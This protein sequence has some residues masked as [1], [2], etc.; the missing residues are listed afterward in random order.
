MEVWFFK[1]VSLTSKLIKF[2]TWSKYSH[3]SLKFSDDML[4]EAWHKTN[5]VQMYSVNEI[6]SVHKNGTKID[7]Y[8]LNNEY[9]DIQTKLIIE[10]KIKSNS[11]FYLNKKYDFLGVLGFLT[12]SK[13]K[14]NRWF[15]SEII[16]KLF[17][18]I[19]I[20]LINTESYKVYPGLLSYSPFLVKKK[21]I[22]IKHNK[23][24]NLY[25]F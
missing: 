16:H 8:E 14:N 21:E 4:L 25:D 11:F 18:D 5:S 15:C 10:E 9:F 20:I 7:V 17:K 13:I 12:K 19:G 3:V 22:I 23:I 24:E 1:G 2:F 6:F